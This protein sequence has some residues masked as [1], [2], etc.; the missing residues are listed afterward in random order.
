MDTIDF[1]RALSLGLGRTVLYLADHDAISYGEMILDACLHNRAYDPQVEG[2]RAGYMFDI[3]RRSGDAAFYADA[4]IR[5]LSD[6]EHDWDTPQRFE[7]A[8]LLAQS[9]NPFARE[10]MYSAFRAKE[11]SAS[12]IAAQFVELDGIQGLLF[13]ARQIGEQ[14]ARNQDQWEDDQLLLMAFEICGRNV[15]DAA[16]SEASN[17]DEAI[18]L[19]LTAVEKNQTLRSQTQRPDPKTL[20]Y[21]QIRSLIESKR[22]GGLLR[23]WATAAS[24]SDM[25]PAARA[26]VQ[27]EDLDRLKSYLVLFWKR[28]FPLELDRLFQLVELPDGPIPRHTL[29]VLANM[30]HEGIRRLAYKLV[31]DKSSLRGYAIDLLIKN[32]RDEDYLAVEVWCDSEQDSGTFNAFDR[33]LKEFFVAHPNPEIEM[34]LLTKA[35]EK[36]PCAHCRSYAVQRLLEMNS[37]TDAL[38][39]EAEYDSY[40]ETRALVKAQTS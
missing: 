28:R 34:R 14:L 5:S 21:D 36:E 26:L 16:L 17:T 24:D 33:S 3:I 8:R 11:L 25:E 22:A 9:G 23:G 39:R 31:E 20:T 10:A 29:R 7:L 38:K 4:V 15:V 1:Q 19:Y 6:E 27:E 32:F 12:D 30:E 37:L 35:Y 13:A 2:S 18:K 40:A